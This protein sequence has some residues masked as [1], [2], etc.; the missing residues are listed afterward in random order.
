MQ[1][2]LL[3]FLLLPLDGPREGS[4]RQVEVRQFLVHDLGL[5]DRI[6]H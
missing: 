1:L 5:C 3:Q 4:M 2:I 6:D